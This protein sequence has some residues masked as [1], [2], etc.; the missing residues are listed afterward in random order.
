VPKSANQI[1]NQIGILLIKFRS[2]ALA[3]QVPPTG[4]DLVRRAGRLRRHAV[5]PAASAEPIALSHITQHFWSAVLHVLSGAGGMESSALYQEIFG[6]RA[7]LRLISI[8][9][10]AVAIL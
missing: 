2:A 9:V 6:L 3:A 7:A 1:G 8:S 4:A 5:K 10:R